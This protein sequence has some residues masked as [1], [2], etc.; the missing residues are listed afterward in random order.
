MSPEAAA[1]VAELGFPQVVEDLLAQAHALLPGL[2]S[3][4]LSL[5]SSYEMDDIPWLVLECSS[6]RPER[7][8]RDGL[9]AWYTWRAENLPFEVARHFMLDW[10]QHQ[11]THEG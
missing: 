4:H 5:V 10:I 1:R 9:V 8:A 7:E 11:E 6:A 2:R 3:I